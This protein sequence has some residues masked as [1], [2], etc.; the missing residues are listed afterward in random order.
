MNQTTNPSAAAC[1]DKQNRPQMVCLF[2][3]MYTRFVGA[4]ISVS[5]HITTQV[6]KAQGAS[7]NAD[8]GQ[9]SPSASSSVSPGT[10]TKQGT[11]ELRPLDVAVAA[12]MIC[13][14]SSLCMTLKGM[15]KGTCR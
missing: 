5:Y 6:G 15:C 8:N 1:S 2:K 14:I 4:R 10:M 3:D 13:A 9:A 12:M 7:N 11:L